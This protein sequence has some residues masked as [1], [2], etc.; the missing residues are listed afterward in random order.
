MHTNEDA[1][2]GLAEL[3]G[4]MGDSK[5]AAEKLKAAVEKNPNPRT[6][7]ALARAYEDLNDYK[8]AADA[9]K[10]RFGTGRG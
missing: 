4:Q 9:L 5:R 10:R 2:V 8:D 1:L 6:L 7:F 3:Y